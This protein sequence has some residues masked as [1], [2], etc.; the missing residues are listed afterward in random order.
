M[1]SASSGPP[2]NLEAHGIT[3]QRE[4]GEGSFSRVY[5]GVHKGRRYAI[6]VQ[7]R[8]LEPHHFA[9]VVR[10]IVA[11]PVVVGVRMVV[12]V[13][14]TVGVAI[15]PMPFVGIPL[16]RMP[17]MNVPF[18]DMRV[19]PGLEV[20]HRRLDTVRTAAGSAH[21]AASNSI[22]LML[23]SSPARRSR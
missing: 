21:Q 12:G 20:G 4:I 8:G 16:V 5:S 17:L 7:H 14:V 23:S 6:K 18:V 11:G 22:S 2:P 13:I 15:V 9:V 10:V 19:L 3:L 1:A